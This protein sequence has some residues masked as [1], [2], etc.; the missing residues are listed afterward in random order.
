MAYL[1]EINN[2]NVSINDERGEN[3]KLI[4]NFSLTIREG[5]MVGLIGETG[6]G[7]SV[8]ARILGGFIQDNWKIECQ[9]FRFKGQEL[10]INNSTID[11]NFLSAKVGVIYQDPKT[12]FDTSK[13]IGKQILDHMYK[14]RYFE[15]NNKKFSKFGWIR[16]KQEIKELE[17]ILT[18]IGIKDPTPI[19]N[20]YLSE[21]SD[22]SAHLMSVALAVM[23]ERELLIADEP[24]SGLNSVSASRVQSL[25]KRLNGNFHK[26]IL[27]L[28]N[29]FENVRDLVKSAHI[30][31]FGQ[32]VE[33]IYQVQDIPSNESIVSYVHHPY[34]HLFLKSTPNFADGKLIFKSKLYAIPGELPEL[35]NIP[36]GC[37]FAPKCQFA[38]RECMQTPGYTKDKEWGHSEFACHHPIDYLTPKQVDQ[39]RDYMEDLNQRLQTMTEESS[40]SN[41]DREKQL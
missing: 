11:T 23:M 20:S 33:R 24:T 6:S 29:N 32:I 38:Q 8:L 12:V 14:S 40:E 34:T 1:L 10:L 15:K 13:K 4:D 9:S 16:K 17:N 37:R 3:L 5:E 7:K 30:M 39:I 21:L 2:L 22:T 41:G 19:L 26:T 36:V 25:F 28:S 18:R 27:Y 31:Y 35:S